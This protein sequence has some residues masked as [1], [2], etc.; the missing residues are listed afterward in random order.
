MRI[1]L[2]PEPAEGVTP[3]VATPE[4]ASK[5]EAVTPPVE[6]PKPPAPP[7]PNPLAA[8]LAATRARLAELEAADAERERLAREAEEE[9]LR[10][11][12][13]FEKLIKQRD[14]DLATEKAKAAAA[15]DRAK[16]Y[17]LNTELAIAFSSHALV[18]GSA[19]D[20]SE[21]WRKDFEVV[22]DGDTWAARS[23]DGR[24]VKEVIAERLAGRWSNHVKAEARSGSG[25]GNGNVPAP[26]P[27]STTPET[28]AQRQARQLKEVMTAD[29]G[30]AI[31]IIAHTSSRN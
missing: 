21:L 1:L 10:A 26:T 20:L 8:D 16:A 15:T 27:T 17:A 18:E 28:S 4:V 31:G 5:A 12:G 14:A 30:G 9:K 29:R 22:A 13:E 11:K 2:N 7:A 24:T 25:G 19:E 6:T 23:K 3:P